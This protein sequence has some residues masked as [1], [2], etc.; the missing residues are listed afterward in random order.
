MLPYASLPDSPDTPTDVDHSDEYS[1]FSD[2]LESLQDPTSPLD[3]S[4]EPSRGKALISRSDTF[5]TMARSTGGTEFFSAVILDMPRHADDS[6]DEVGEG[7]RN[8][9][10]WDDIG[11]SEE[12]EGEEGE[13]RDYVGGTLPLRIQKRLQRKASE[14]ISI[15]GMVHAN[16]S[17]ET[18][19]HHLGPCI[20]KIEHVLYDLSYSSF[21]AQSI[22]EQYHFYNII[23]NPSSSVDFTNFS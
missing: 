23:L 5:R 15:N 1:P 4:Y 12:E 2:T 16:L 21:L 20:S 6:T 3:P 10:V 22:K 14:L 19:L 7:E 18:S 9:S 17:F 8:E 11:Q 13:K